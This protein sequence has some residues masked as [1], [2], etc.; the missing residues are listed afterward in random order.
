M[1]GTK[2]LFDPRVSS[3]ASSLLLDAPFVALDLNARLCRSDRSAYT[4]TQIR[5]IVL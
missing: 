1:Y 5:A 4:K 2:H 3:T